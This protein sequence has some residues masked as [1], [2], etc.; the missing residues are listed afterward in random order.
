MRLNVGVFLNAVAE[1]S[2]ITFDRR[3][4]KL[5]INTPLIMNPPD[6]SAIHVALNTNLET[7]AFAIGKQTA[8]AVLREAL[9]LGIGN[10]CLIESDSSM[11]VISY[12]SLLARAFSDIGIDALF[13]GDTT[14][15]YGYTG[16]AEA[17]AT[18][19]VASF[20]G[21]IS[22]AEINNGKCIVTK[23]HLGKSL[24]VEVP[25]PCIFTVSQQETK[26]YPTPAGILDAYQKKI[27]NRLIE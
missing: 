10:A 24:K 27:K 11:N 25:I 20:I 23:I 13:F 6:R 17:T 8:E 22:S 26:R 2:K 14:I 12:A 7:Y 3:S 16:I 4:G 15:D 5:I 19:V 21:N 9:A 1:P 18:K